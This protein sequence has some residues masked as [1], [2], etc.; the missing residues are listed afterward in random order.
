MNNLR[1]V[2]DKVELVALPAA[3]YD[4]CQE[5][6]P[7]RKEKLFEEEKEQVETKMPADVL[8]GQGV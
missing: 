2:E 8:E 4:A 3:I 5:V 1:E 6:L 7:K